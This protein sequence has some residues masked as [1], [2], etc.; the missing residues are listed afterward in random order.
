M[1]LYRGKYCAL[2]PTSPTRQQYDFRFWLNVHRVCSNLARIRRKE[3][4]SKLMAVQTAEVH[5]N[6]NCADDGFDDFD[7][8]D[9]DFEVPAPV[10]A[11]PSEAGRYDWHDVVGEYN[12]HESDSEEE[13]EEIDEYDFVSKVGINVDQLYFIILFQVAKTSA[14]EYGEGKYHL[15]RAIKYIL[16]RKE[17]EQPKIADILENYG[18]L[19]ISTELAKSQLVTASTPKEIEKRKRLYFDDDDEMMSD[20]DIFDDSDASPSRNRGSDENTEDDDYE[21]DVS[22]NIE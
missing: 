19:D 2:P 13:E 12:F 16:S 9:V 10:P 20:D 8:G 17:Y 3:A 4:K 15:K 5:E 6:D 1:V 7:G 18:H 22:L 11:K 14:I 21:E